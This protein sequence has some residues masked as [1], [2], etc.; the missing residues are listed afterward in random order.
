MELIVAYWTIGRLQ[1]I[2]YIQCS[3][4]KQC[5]EESLRMPYCEKPGKHTKVNAYNQ[6]SCHIRVFCS[7]ESTVF[8]ILL[9]HI[10]EKSFL[11]SPDFR[12]EHLH[13]RPQHIKILSPGGHHLFQHP[14]LHLFYSPI[15]FWILFQKISKFID[16][17]NN[18]VKWPLENPSDITSLFYIVWW[19]VIT[20]IKY[21]LYVEI[22]KLAIILRQKEG[23][24][25]DILTHSLIL[26]YFTK[27]TSSSFSFFIKK[28]PT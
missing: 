26:S 28:K 23:W 13:K 10:L 8:N 17:Y 24:C 25:D 18:N 21:Y 6:H 9:Q 15:L 4:R 12:F 19:V 3:K 5:W 22:L 27:S 11:R 1:C 20:K 2:Q 16:W 14:P 7:N